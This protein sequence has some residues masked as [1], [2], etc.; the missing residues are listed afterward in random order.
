M[1]TLLKNRRLRREKKAK[2]RI[3]F[4][5]QPQFILIDLAGPWQ[6][7]HF[8]NLLS[9]SGHT[10]YVLDVV[11]MTANPKVVAH[12]D[13][14]MVAQRSGGSWKGN[15]DTIIVP[16]ALGM[17][18]M[19][20]D[21]PMLRRFRSLAG[22]SRRVAAVCFGAF[23]LAAAG[24]LN[25]RRATTHWRGCDLLAQRYPDVTVEPDMIFVKDGNVYTSAGAT[26]GID[27]ALALVE[28]DLG[29]ELALDV[30]R[31]LVMFIRRPGGQTQF[32]AALESQ[33]TEREPLRELLS[34]ATEHPEKNLTVESMAAR[35]HMS[36]RNFS[37][38]FL[39][40]IGKTPARFVEQLRV[41]AARQRLEETD[42]NLEI[43]SQKCGFGSAN[44]MRRSF[45]RVLNVPPSEYR[46]RFQSA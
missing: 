6:V 17:E 5:V 41:D 1:T 14:T 11:S 22:K 31:N 16:A 18:Q 12:G 43:V 20:S 40:E 30:A 39:R 2:R 24:L 25:G 9:S 28:E 8:A 42:A 34:W 32:S 38:V 46:E 4:L 35:V 19:P 37:R 23:F 7:F 45:L 27:M 33:M 3:V 13:L 26:A 44:S 10:P 15:V 21:T 36:P 29:R